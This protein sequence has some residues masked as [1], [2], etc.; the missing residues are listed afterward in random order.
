MLPRWLIERY[1]HFLLKRRVPISIAIGIGTVF[2]VWLTAT[3]L[4]MFT[5]FFDL[6]PPGHPYIQVYTKYR[7]LF[8]SSNHAEVSGST[9]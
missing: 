6:Y 9:A 5:N 7:S 4:T 3:R 8:G 2:F 1:L